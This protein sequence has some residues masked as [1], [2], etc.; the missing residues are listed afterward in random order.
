M[1]EKKEKQYVSDNAQLM[2]EWDVDR[3]IDVFP[4]QISIW[5]HKKVWW[6]CQNGH[7]W[8]TSPHHRIYGTNCPYCS[9]KKTIAGHN[10]LATLFPE[11]AREWNNDKNTEIQ[12]NCVSPQSNKKVWWICAKGHEWEAI[13]AHRTKGVGCPYCSNKKV[14]PGYNDLATTHPHLAS[15]WHPT[16]NGELKPSDITHGAGILVWWQCYLGHEWRTTPN[17]RTSDNTSCPVCA[18]KKIAVGFNDLETTHPRLA[19]EWHPTLN[20]SLTPK[21]V[22]FGSSKK[23]WWKCQKGH[24]WKASISNRS[25]NRNCPVCSNQTKTSFPE[26]AIYHYL[27]KHFPDVE[28]QNTSAIGMELDIY[29]PSIKT[30]IEY[31]GV[32]YHHTSSASTREEKKNALCG[33][34]D[35]RLIRIRENG[36]DIYDACECIIV[37][38]PSKIH[39]IN[40]AIERL[41]KLLNIND[42]HIDILKDSSEILDLYL[43]SE[44]ERSLEKNNFHLVSEWHPIKNGNLK[45]EHLAE[46][47]SRIV[48]WLCKNG[49]E[50]QASLHNRSKGKGCPYCSGRTA[51]M[52]EN[53]LAT[54]RPDLVKEW[55]F[56][57]NNPL[58]PTNVKAGSNQRV[59]WICI[60]CGYKWQA[61][62]NGRTSGHGCP[63]C[64]ELKK[65]PKRKSHETFLQELK[66]INPKI[67]LIGTYA[68]STEKVMCRCSVCAHEWY[69]LPG[70]LLKGKGCP[71]CAKAR[72][73]NGKV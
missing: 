15:E 45:P 19:Q 6:H 69:A 53:D 60:A 65:G 41:L 40:Q 34:K 63:K 30:A 66:V 32:Y 1:A 58:L 2:A 3:N 51:I 7:N 9:G 27:K 36:L 25:K 12:V 14:L 29:I 23:A 28:N 68:V 61:T 73:K 13:I 21:D 56:E 8:E 59:G 35:I 71:E 47:S 20:G 10:D 54:V 4:S 39:S 37:E 43:L 16:K 17:K 67:E 24:E 31:D 64:A 22:T 57:S 46:N 50:W 72:R 70:N 49:H 62:V 33:T 11:V 52:G 38:N 44:I 55:D 48:W 18:N 26:Q 42:F 5:S